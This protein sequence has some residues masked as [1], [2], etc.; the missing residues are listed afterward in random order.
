MSVSSVEVPSTADANGRRT[1]VRERRLPGDSH[2]WVMVLGEFFVFGSYFV[3]YMLDRAS[4]PD[5]YVASQEHL[6][7]G[8]G[9]LNT[10]ILMTSSLLVALAVIATK[11]GDA[12]SAERKVLA[13][14]ACGLLFTVIKAYEWHHEAQYY[15]IH[16][17]FLSHYYALTGVHMFHLLVGLI[18]L[19]V[20]VRE[21]RD[22]RRQRLGT[23]EQGALYWHMIDV[24][25]V[26]IFAVLYLMR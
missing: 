17:E 24:I 19:G 11:H 9:V 6:N 8:L 7:V 26:V 4:S 21:L 12:K 23:V 14:G 5:D 13:A 15:S 20:V 16:N 25:W 3:V 10:I 22:P 1:G 2:I 18:V